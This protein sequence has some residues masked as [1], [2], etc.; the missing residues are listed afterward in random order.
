MLSRN[1]DASIR[2]WQISFSIGS[3][4]ADATEDDKGRNDVMTYRIDYPEK[5]QVFGQKAKQF[6]SGQAFVKSEPKAFSK[7]D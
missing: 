4:H 2:H 3:G 6:T 1:C 5:G 7:W